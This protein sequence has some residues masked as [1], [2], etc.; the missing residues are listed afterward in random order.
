MKRFNVPCVLLS[1][2]MLVSIFTGC[3]KSS[4]KT[5]DLY[6][7]IPNFKD[8]E[9][10]YGGK[11]FRIMV[12]GSGDKPQTEAGESDKLNLAKLHQEVAKRN[13]IGKIVWD[14]VGDW[15]TFQP[16]LTAAVLANN[17]P[18]IAVMVT[19][20]YF[21]SATNNQI[22]EIPEAQK[23][24]DDS[25]L[26]LDKVSLGYKDNG[27]YYGLLDD[28]YISSAEGICYNKDLMKK[29]S[30]E[31]PAKL[32]LEDKWDFDTFFKYCETL[33]KDTDGDGVTDIYGYGCPGVMD[34]RADALNFLSANGADMLI[35][36]NNRFEIGFTDKKALGGL[37]LIKKILFDNSYADIELSMDFTRITGM[38]KNQ[39]V[40][41]MGMSA[42]GVGMAESFPAGFVGY[43]KGPDAGDNYH[44]WNESPN[45]ICVPKGSGSAD[46][47]ANALKVYEQIRLSNFMTSWTDQN[48]TGLD[49]DILGSIKQ[50]L[51]NID[52]KGKIAMTDYS[53]KSWAGTEITEYTYPALRK[54]IS[55]QEFAPFEGSNEFRFY[56]KSIFSDIAFGDNDPEGALKTH[57][58]TFQPV[59]DRDI[60]DVLDAFEAEK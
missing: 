34:G 43:P 50:E 52:S 18:D 27:K 37:N 19:N 30:L 16:S 26:Y 21:P 45:M 28:R 36:N 2:V 12:W 14:N 60:N 59:I 3:G 56:G 6:K 44:M 9:I 32:F 58:S 35:R 10:D 46:N 53:L 22:C 17:A 38:F 15:M 51:D 55:H 5:G 11:D 47:P 7:Q 4:A 42:W 54:V 25:I 23:I 29:Y 57:K 33:S 24:V 20:W 39:K 31:D 13:N 40:A 49:A 48:G 8:S 41:M 1:A